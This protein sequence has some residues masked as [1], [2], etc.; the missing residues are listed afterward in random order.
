MPTIDD[1]TPLQGKSGHTGVVHGSGFSSLT[2]TV[3]FG[4]TSAGEIATTSDKVVKFKIPVTGAGDR[5]PDDPTK[6]N[7]TVAIGGVQASFVFQYDPTGTQPVI[8]GFDP[9]SFTTGTSRSPFTHL[10][11]KA[12]GSDF[13][14]S[15]GRR[16]ESAYIPDLGL[17]ATSVSFD[18]A[19]PGEVGLTF[20]SPTN[21]PASAYVVLVGFSDDA[22]AA[23][24]I[25]VNPAA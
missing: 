13:T 17:K 7:V 1:L 21:I 6:A 4:A 24:S 12:M 2:A 19:M 10:V 8:T 23:G 9:A 5:R 25:T 22:G 18:P 3:L 11:T 16:P 20:D 15:Q 14:N